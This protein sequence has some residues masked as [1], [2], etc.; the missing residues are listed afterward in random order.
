MTDI[1]VLH[2]N[3]FA[4]GGG[5]RVADSIAD[6][7]DAPLYYGF[8][9]GTPDDHIE[10]HK[11]Y[12]PTWLGQKLVRRVYQYRDF[13]FM[14]HGTHIPQAHE[15]DV[16][17]ESG[18][19]F[20]WYVPHKMEQA[21]VKYVHSPPRGPYDMHHRHGDSV[22]HRVYSLA[23]KTLYEHTTT[24]PD[25]YVANSEVVAQRCR[26]AWG[27]DPEIVYPPVDVGKYGPANPDTDRPN[28]F[29]TFS[30]LY[31]HKRTREIVQ[32]FTGRDETLIVGGDGPQK[33]EL[34]AIAPSNVEIRGYLG[35]EEKQRLLAECTALIFN[36]RNEDFGIVPIEAMA[37]GTPVIGVNDG[38]TRY[39]IKDG[40]TGI[41]YDN[42]DDPSQIA[43]AVS[44]YQSHG[45]SWDTD[46]IES[47]ADQFSRKR[48]E[49][50]MQTMVEKA[51]ARCEMDS[52]INT[53]V[54]A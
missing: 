28:T 50:E 24:Y 32:A 11:L 17:V 23:A 2:G 3:Y 8:G 45:V 39:Q 40:Q 12:D 6:A 30:R 13:K 1:A 38:F 10:R 7:F 33:E 27:V 16:I 48:F 18:N 26:K 20:G 14:W 9:D 47:Y 22:L 34:E 54:N 29:L 46:A 21:V 41:L 42:G 35:G 37:S 36:A 44:R 19:E 43:S 15:Y 5:E 4:R 31:R 25:V 51:M 53:T 52:E 49:Q